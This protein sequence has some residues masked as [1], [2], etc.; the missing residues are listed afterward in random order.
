[1][2]NVFVIINE[3]T[4]I[5]NST[6]AEV[7]GANFFESEGDAWVALNAIAEAH[8]TRLYLDETSLQFEDH[9][10]HLQHEEYYIQEL[11]RG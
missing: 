10:P 1:M 7:V 6:G 8:D 11:T 5:D 4:S 3:W 9:Q 2:S